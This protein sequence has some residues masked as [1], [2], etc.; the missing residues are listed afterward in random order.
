MQSMYALGMTPVERLKWRMRETEERTAR[1]STRDLMHKWTGLP[2]ARS[3][4]SSATVTEEV[5]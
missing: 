1:K 3:M 4:G 2:L 5:E